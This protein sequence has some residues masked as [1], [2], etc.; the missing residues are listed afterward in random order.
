MSVDGEGLDLVVTAENPPNSVDEA[1]IEREVMQ[2]L[3]VAP[4]EFVSVEGRTDT[5]ASVAHARVAVD[6]VALG[7]AVR[8]NAAVDPGDRVTVSKAA[9]AP[10]EQVTVAPMRSVDVREGEVPLSRVLAG[11]PVSTG[12][13]L[14][15]SLLDG[16]LSVTFEVTDTVPDG[17]VVVTEQT[18]VVA[19]SEPARDDGPGRVTF[20]EVGGLAA[21]KT[22][23]RDAVVLPLENPGRFEQFGEDPAGG[24]LLTG[25]AGVGKTHLAAAVATAVSAH[26]VWI[27]SADVA[28]MRSPAV[29]EEFDRV[30]REVRAKA[31]A[32]VVIDDLDA[33]AP[34]ADRASDRDRRVA[35]HLRSLLDDL[36]DEP[37]IA[38]LATAGDAADVDAA[39]RRGG[40][41]EREIDLPVPDR[42]A[43]REVLAVRTSDVPLATDVSLDR[44]AD[45]THG[46]VGA[47]LGALVTEAVLSAAR[48]EGDPT[49]VSAADFEAAL[50][51][52][53]PSAMRRVDVTVPSVGYDDVGG[54]ADAKR[55][56]TRSVEWPLRYPQLFEYLDATPPRGILLY[57]PPGTGK[58]MLAKAVANATDAN[59]VSVKGPEVLEKW[60]GESERAIRD[61]FETARQNAPSI[62]FFDEVDAISV[63][64]GGDDGTRAVERVV[65]Q[66]LTEL[67]GLE[68]LE[69]VVVIGATNRPD[70]IDPALLR[71]GRFERLVEVGMPDREGRRDIFAV[72]TRTVPTGDVD[73]D[74]L[75]AETDGYTGS[76]IA[77]V[78]REASMLAIEAYVEGERISQPRVGA[79]HFARAL[80]TVEPTAERA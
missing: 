20:E 11:R 77:A 60:V 5:V 70:V 53:E 68:P 79:E 4:G 27:D 17:P 78:V 52:V 33:V 12:D 49:A 34:A 39:L 3:D 74:A 25:P 58:T 54:M 15:A 24:V 72:H 18:T 26:V 45:R 66:L 59:F 67:D 55:A 9:V 22:A 38:V 73:L 47:D 48:R 41:L 1:G 40:R 32:L 6:G 46:F 21:A 42:A 80:A 13:A 37:G 36:A 8:S 57:G 62:V 29:G 56:L 7:Q 44:I 19:R 71:P 23:L 75:A 10:A 64:R 16:S 14:D 65:S 69:D 51:A 30:A 43:R 28:G 76:D 61:I 50:D 2:R 35:T 31:P 63:R